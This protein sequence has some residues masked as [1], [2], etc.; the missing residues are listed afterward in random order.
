MT[1]LFTHP[2]RPISKCDRRL[3]T[4]A[5]TLFEIRSSPGAFEKMTSLNRS[6]RP[7]LRTPEHPTEHL[8]ADISPL[9]TAPRPEP[10]FR[11]L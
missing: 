1:G 11:V 2:T 7:L 4:N 6:P 9:A 10:D 3:G 8:T 5:D